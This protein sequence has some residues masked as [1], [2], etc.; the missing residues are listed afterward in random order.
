MRRYDVYRHSDCVARVRILNGGTIEW[1]YRQEPGDWQG[2]WWINDVKLTIEQALL[3]WPERQDLAI[4]EF[5]LR[6]CGD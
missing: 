5:T 6:R 4:A 2:F 1:V 3:H